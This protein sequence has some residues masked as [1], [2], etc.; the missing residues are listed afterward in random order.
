[1]IYHVLSRCQTLSL[2]NFEDREVK[3]LIT[4]KHGVETENRDKISNI[5]PIGVYEGGKKENKRDTI[6]N[7]KMDKEGVAKMVE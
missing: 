6:C 1:M 5:H 4:W 7:K 3:R 2:N